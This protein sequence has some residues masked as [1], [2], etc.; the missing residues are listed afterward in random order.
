MIA[1]SLDTEVTALGDSPFGEEGNVHL[2]RPHLQQAVLSP[3]IMDSSPQIL[4]PHLILNECIWLACPKSHYDTRLAQLAE[5]LDVPVRKVVG[6]VQHLDDVANPFENLDVLRE[7]LD[8]GYLVED[9]RTQIDLCATAI[10]CGTP[11]AKK[12]ERDGDEQ[13]RDLFPMAAPFFHMRERWMPLAYRT[14]YLLN[15]LSALEATYVST[16][17]Y[18]V[19]VHDCLFCFGRRE[20]RAIREGF[21]NGSLLPRIDHRPYTLSILARA[22]PTAIEDGR[23]Q[24]LLRSALGSAGAK[25]E[26]SH[27]LESL[28]NLLYKPPYYLS[29]LE[30]EQRLTREFVALLRAVAP[31]P[32]RAA[33]LG[34][35]AN[36]PLP[37]SLPNPV[38][39]YSA[40]KDYVCNKRLTAEFGWLLYLVNLADALPYFGRAAIPPIPEVTAI[41]LRDDVVHTAACKWVLNKRSGTLHCA[42]CRHLHQAARADVRLF[43]D[44][45]GSRPNVDAKRCTSCCG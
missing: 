23:S 29:E 11:E 39:L 37:L 40:F 15:R 27:E 45:L 18:E 19:R 10:L 3:A 38:S 32:V 1:D 6:K 12:L 8:P 4:L 2:R 16:D 9:I 21:E 20:C 7:V 14:R 42:G 41:L 28:A 30:L 36:I 34:L 43:L 44:S 24:G 5:L 26:L 25:A 22:L 13:A 35:V 33:L 31:S 17:E